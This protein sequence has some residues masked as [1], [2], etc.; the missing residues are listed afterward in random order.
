MSE[1][2]IRFEEG[3]AYERMMV[4]WLLSFLCASVQELRRGPA[5]LHEQTS[6]RP[7]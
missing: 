5:T 4:V 6:T 7:T 3:A 2:R 1:L